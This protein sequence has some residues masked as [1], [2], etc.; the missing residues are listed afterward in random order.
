MSKALWVVAAIATLVGVGFALDAARTRIATDTGPAAGSIPHSER[1]IAAGTARIAEESRR[2]VPMPDLESAP[3]AHGVDA[4]SLEPEKAVPDDPPEGYAFVHHHGEMAKARMD[5]EPVAKQL[6]DIG[7]DWLQS[8]DAIA[9]LTHQATAAGRDWSF[10]WIRLSAGVTIADLARDI[11]GTGAEILGNSGRMIR[12]RLPADPSSLEAITSLDA[13]D[14]IGATP[15][16]SK[17]ASFDDGSILRDPDGMTPVYVTLMADDA[18]GRWRKAMEGLGAVVGGYDPALRVYR[19]NVRDDVMQAL[20]AADFVLAIE[21][22]PIVEVAHDTAVPAM[23]ADALRAYDGSPGVY[24]G[25]AG[26]SVPVAVMDTGLNINHLD[27]ASHRDSICGANFA[28]NSGWYGPDGPLVEDE[29]LWIDSFGHGT[30]VT[31]TMAGNGFV[32]RRFA[33]MAPGV[34]HIR[35]AKV[36]DTYGGGFGDSIRA[37]MDFLAVES[38]C[39]EAGRMSA[40]VKPLIVNMSLSA[41]A[42]VFEGRDVGARKLDSTVWSNRQLYVVSQSNEGISGFSNYGAAKNSLAVGA[43]LDDGTLAWFSSH[44]PTADG[45]LAP[46]VVGAGVRVYSAQGDGSRGAYRP[47]NGT[48]MSSPAVAGVAALLMDA[49]PAHREQPALARARLMASAVRPDPWLADGAG[50]PA[51]NSAGPGPLQDRFGMGKVSARTAALDRDRPDGWTSGSAA[52]ELEDGE[53]AYHDIEVP[54]GASRLDLVMTWDEAP[55]D[56]VA[57]TVLNDLDLWL[58][59]DGDCATEACGEHSSRSRVDNVEWVIVRNPEPG[60]YRA[61]VLAHRVYTEAPRAALAWTVI[62]G[63]STPTLTV[64][65]D[66]VRI[67]GDGEHE[68]TLTLKSDAYVAAGTRLHI[69][70]RTDGA[71]NCNELV[72][73]ESATLSRED[74]VEVNLAEETQ[75]PVPS[76]YHWSSRPINLGAS[77]PIGEV[78]VGDERQVTLRVTMNGA[79]GNGGARLLFTASAWNGSAG[80]VAVGLGPGS[81]P[82]LTK[83][84]NDDFAAASVI[85][86][87]EGSVALD[88]LH[89]TPEPGEAA[90]DSR[91]GRPAGTLWY[92]WTAP[93]DGTFRFKVP[94]LAA[95]YVDRDGVVRYDRVQVFQG[96]RVAALREVAASL[97]QADFFA[98]R[99][100][101]YRIRIASSSRGA[102]M[103]L[104]WSPGGRPANDDF[105][106]CRHP[107]W[108]V[109]RRGTAAASER[110]CR[111][112]SRSANAAATTWYRW[113]APSDGAW[114]FVVPHPKQCLRSKA[115]ACR[116]CGSFPK[117]RAPT[118]ILWLA[119]AGSIALRLPRPVAVP[120]R[121]RT[122]FPGIP[123]RHARATT[124]SRTLSRSGTVP[125]RNR[126]STSTA[127]RPL[128]RTNPPKP[129]SGRSGGGGMHR[130][131]AFIRGAS[132]MSG[133][134]CRAIR[135]CA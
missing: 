103:D 92:T 19:A 76:G 98:E 15:P 130:R 132:R 4:P 47:S 81:L 31:G 18:D 29:D 102:A 119:G 36:L 77:I 61:K 38:G 23:G 14:M 9:G 65:A 84:A 60:T 78:A 16:E 8:P 72:T 68:L 42:R 79:S 39:S 124:G 12:A 107:G 94:A 35:F 74:G 112:A 123:R 5:S 114:L 73:V 22:I 50:F 125:R 6:D 104:G 67:E 55:A 43:I 90:F 70:C 115:T 40:Q 2:G 69:D 111:P 113:T 83:P 97:W 51:D 1:I 13:V 89:A 121:A 57:S 127:D 26:S 133:R 120:A 37:G 58:D 105:A 101:T 34:R 44:G 75:S 27:I 126:L 59:R 109:G 21:P 63:A 62:R 64:E 85:A 99:G 49:V 71:S 30:H 11:D 93:S 108:G 3:L 118:P 82:E 100:Q 106:Q 122:S 116:S 87:E 32:D 7:P 80:S 135:S 88:L 117:G 28:Y 110:R 129:A 41:S 56:A 131:T 17:L 96:D 24:S 25:T 45:R 46:N 86:D 48:S 54:A 10:G 66:R 134:W 128:N 53:Y 52:A 95:D 20:A 91:R 33:G